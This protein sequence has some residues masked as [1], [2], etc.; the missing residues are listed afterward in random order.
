MLL[1]GRPSS[2][3]LAACPWQWSCPLAA[4][5]PR[6]VP[7]HTQSPWGHCDAPGQS[8]DTLRCVRPHMRGC[9]RGSASSAGARVV[10][11][12]HSCGRGF[13]E[14]GHCNPAPGT[15]ALLAAL[16]GDALAVCEG[17]VCRGL[18]SEGHGDGWDVAHPLRP[19]RSPRPSTPALP[20]TWP[21]SPIQMSSRPFAQSAPSRALTADGS[22]GRHCPSCTAPQAQRKG[23][24]PGKGGCQLQAVD[25]EGRLFGEQDARVSPQNLCYEC[26]GGA[27]ALGAELPGI[28]APLPRGSVTWSRWHWSLSL[29]LL[30]CEMGLR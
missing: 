30:L 29:R 15:R 12:A 26:G 1:G 19:P 10:G 24:W 27:Q 9:A 6:T 28:P 5:G 21:S 22:Q 13:W 4:I 11:Q 17:R 2:W 20:A 8:G 23:G 25:F 18:S 16:P 14:G 3:S 7:R